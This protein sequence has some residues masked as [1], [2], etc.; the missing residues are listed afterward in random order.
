MRL[1]LKMLV[2]CFVLVS[3][4]SI[5]A[6][7]SLNVVIDKALQHATEQSLLMAKSLENEVG[8]LPRSYVNG[9]LTTSDSR[10]WCSGYFPGVLWY[11]F[12][13]SKNNE[14]LKYAEEF[15]AR[16]EREKYT[17][18][19][20]DVGLMI[21][22]SFGNGYRITKK[23]A[24]REV[25]LTAAESLS[26]R[27]NE[28]VGLIRSWDF[29]KS[30]WQYPVIIDNMMNLDLLLW[31]SKESGNQRFRNISISH[32]NKTMKHHYRLDMS[33]YH[34]VS[35]D[36]ITGL[37][38]KKQTSQGASDSS[39][40]SRG[41]AWGLYGYT[42]M[43]RETKDVH[44]LEMAKKIANYIFNHP[45]MPSDYIPYWDFNAPGIPNAKRDASAASIM[46]SA[47]TEL[48]GYVEKP[49]RKKYLKIAEIQLRTLASPEYTAN[50][51]ENGNFILKHSVSSIPHKSEVD[52][53]L[54][55]ADYYYVEALLRM[56]SLLRKK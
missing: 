41:Q 47:L 46:A 8:K 21:Y 12:E 22:C 50:I 29:N 4:H 35:Y 1:K 13:N 42:L 30:Q 6:K 5:S 27:Y 33:C 18:D 17:T 34:V 45:N 15:T 36:T 10:W 25:I 20:H 44:Y 23:P 51:G 39:S 56:K 16:V 14:V 55:Y 24:Y 31:A 28:K 2:A 40:W 11:L 38:H 3:I 49:L 43:Y 26:S 48:S 37:P 54:T 7:K 53:P 19:N 52:V 9:K 32:A